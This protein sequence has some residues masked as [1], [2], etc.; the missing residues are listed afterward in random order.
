MN[1]ATPPSTPNACCC[2]PTCAPS[3]GINFDTSDKTLRPLRNQGPMPS[4]ARGTR[5]RAPQS[6]KAISGSPTPSKVRA[7]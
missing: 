4:P 7:I 5:N 6:Q 2:P 1:P 3:Q